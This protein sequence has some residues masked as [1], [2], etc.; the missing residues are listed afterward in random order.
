MNQMDVY[1]VWNIPKGQCGH[2]SLIQ[3]NILGLIIPLSV[4][5]F[6]YSRI[7]P[8]LMAMKSPKKN[9]AVRLMLVLVIVFFLFWTPYNIVIFL[10]F[11]NHLGYMT[12]CHEHGNMAMQWVETLAVSHCCLNSI[13]YAFVGQK[14]RNFFLKILKEW[15]PLCFGQFT[16][17]EG[18][19]S[20]RMTTVHSR[21]S[22]ISSTRQNQKC[23][24]M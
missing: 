7:I 24:C 14:L 22:V 3:L 16:A 21:W 15:F 4:M 13:I 19:F 6:C 12:R 18:E 23:S 17:G 5:V 8:I 2:Y 11:L 9:K 10:R 20:E 1:A